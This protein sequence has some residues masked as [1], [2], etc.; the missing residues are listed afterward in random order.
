MNSSNYGIYVRGNNGQLESN[1]YGVL[2]NI[3]Q[4]EFT[5]LPIMNLVLFQCEWF[6]NTPNIGNTVDN[7]YGIVQVKKS[8]RY[9]KTYDPFIFA[10][11]AEQVYYT[12][13]PEG[14]QG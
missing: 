7:K 11:Q 9:N 12:K 8:R 1:F 6:D 3:I 14:H 5:S 4:L 13:Y 10:Q 2:S